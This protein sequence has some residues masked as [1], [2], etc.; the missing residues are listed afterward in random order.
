MDNPFDTI[1]VV[2][3]KTDQINYPVSHINDQC[4]YCKHLNDCDII[5][6]DLEKDENCKYFKLI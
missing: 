1:S 6:Y 5:S 3:S 4:K 2:D